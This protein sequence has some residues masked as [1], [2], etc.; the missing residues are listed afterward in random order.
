[1]SLLQSFLAEDTSLDT[2]LERL[3]SYLPVA[4]GI[5]GSMSALQQ[6]L[7]EHTHD[8][9]VS[10]DCAD[11]VDTLRD[12]AETFH[13]HLEVMQDL[14]FDPT[15]TLV[16]LRS[17]SALLDAVSRV[18]IV[19][20]PPGTAAL[21]LKGKRRFRQIEV[22]NG[23]V[24]DLVDLAG[25]I[26]DREAEITDYS[27][28]LSALQ[29]AGQEGGETDSEEEGERERDLQQWATLD[30]LGSASVS[31]LDALTASQGKAR[32]MLKRLRD[33]G[34]E[35]TA[36]DIREAKGDVTIL[37]IQI[38]K[39]R[40]S[41]EDKVKLRAQQAALEAEISDMETSLASRTEIFA[42][43]QPYL[44]LPSVAQALSVPLRERVVESGEQ[45]HPCDWGE[46]WVVTEEG[47]V[48]GTLTLRESVAL[49]KVPGGLIQFDQQPTTPPCLQF[50]DPRTVTR[51]SGGTGR[52]SYPQVLGDRVFTSG[53]HK[54]N[55][56]VVH[57]GTCAFGVC[58]SS[59]EDPNGAVDWSK[60]WHVDQSFGGEPEVRTSF[61]DND[62]ITIHLDM[63]S[64][65]ISFI[66][67]G[68]ETIGTLSSVA[69]SVRPW[70]E[71]HV[72][73]VCLRIE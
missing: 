41:E 47:L 49:A 48:E 24:R 1:I 56:R 4:E 42:L 16:S 13:S 7:T 3:K 46:G 61:T 53:T 14:A 43:L 29:S 8:K 31:L 15:C 66:R 32:D 44:F 38:S 25:P 22:A 40:T 50:T 60:T 45:Q 63:E 34:E 23:L 27:K 51:V 62:L 39:R 58:C 6:W 57:T 9:L 68:S 64:H 2:H 72:E 17:V 30:I 21:S 19:P 20:L 11:L 28:R 67:N 12:L 70:F 54:W 26:I 5:S 73:P 71:L 10:A 59:V 35:V 37:G 36:D 55:V 18:D 65:T 69:S 52:T 33:L